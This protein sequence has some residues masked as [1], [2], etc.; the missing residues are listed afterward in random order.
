MKG[1]GWIFLLVSW[2]VVIFWAAWCLRR[3]LTSRQHWT[4]PEE[5]IRELHHGEFGEQ[6]P[7]DPDQK[8]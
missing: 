8:G 4:R 5:D 6:T 3:V 2:G 7:K 1:A